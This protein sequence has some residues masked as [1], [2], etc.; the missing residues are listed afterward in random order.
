MVVWTRSAFA[1]AVYAL[2]GLSASA[3]IYLREGVAIETGGYA[4]SSKLAGQTAKG[5]Y[6]SG[7]WTGSTGVW[8]VNA[9]TLKYPTCLTLME[10]VGGGAFRVQNS[11]ASDSTGRSTGAK[12]VKG[13]PSTGRI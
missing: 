9:S 4:A 3:S 1:A 2:L 8:L 13:L 12:L 10:P 5:E 11:S 6:L 7:S